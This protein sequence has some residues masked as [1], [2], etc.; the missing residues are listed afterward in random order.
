MDG[1]SERLRVRLSRLLAEAAEV[2]AALQKRERG[3]RGPVRYREI[4]LS[5]EESSPVK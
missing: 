3:E 4:E 5:T 2:S 1:E